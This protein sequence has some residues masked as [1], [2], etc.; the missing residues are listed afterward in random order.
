MNI[1]SFIRNKLNGLNNSER[2]TETDHFLFVFF[3]LKE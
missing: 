2:E 1:N 3:F